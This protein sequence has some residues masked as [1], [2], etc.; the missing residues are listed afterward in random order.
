MHMTLPLGFFWI[1]TRVRSTLPPDIFCPRSC[2]PAWATGRM[3]SS[4]DCVGLPLS[5]TVKSHRLLST[6]H[7]DG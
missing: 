3:P 5:I 1:E 2:I 6:N 7:H 4:R